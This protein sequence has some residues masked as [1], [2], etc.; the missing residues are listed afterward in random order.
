MVTLYEKDGNLF[1]GTE[2]EW[3]KFAEQVSF[4]LSWKTERTGTKR[5]AGRIHD[6]KMKEE[7][8]DEMA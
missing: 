3:I 7:Q 6:I 1:S 5:D 4:F 8:M 2:A